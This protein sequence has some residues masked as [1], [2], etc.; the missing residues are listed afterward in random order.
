M[1]LKKEIS[2]REYDKV[3]FQSYYKQKENDDEDEEEE[4]ILYGPRTTWKDNKLI[5]KNNNL[6]DVEKGV[7]YGNE[8]GSMYL[9]YNF[10]FK[11]LDD[12]II[13]HQGLYIHVSLKENK[14]T[15]QYYLNGR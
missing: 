5:Y 13:H 8:A 15:R 1:L 14:I 2:Y 12:W 6:E 9:Y 10:Y 3:T 4:H 7:N 11:Y